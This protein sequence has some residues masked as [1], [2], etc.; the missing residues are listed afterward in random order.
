MGR[1]RRLLDGAQVYVDD[2]VAGRVAGDEATGR[3]I[4]DALSAVPTI[5]AGSFERGLAGNVQDLLMVVRGDGWSNG[6][7][8]WM[9]HGRGWEGRERVRCDNGVHPGLWVFVGPSC[10]AAAHI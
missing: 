4:A 3:A 6:M 9:G 8:G 7:D 2:V 10:V 5:D 1:L